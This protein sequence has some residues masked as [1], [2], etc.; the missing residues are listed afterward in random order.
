M[1]NPKTLPKIQANPLFLGNRLSS[2][3]EFDKFQLQNL[4]DVQE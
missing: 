2:A 4:N 3:Q 1:V